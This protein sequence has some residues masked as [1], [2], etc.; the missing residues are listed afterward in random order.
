MT[1]P[2]TG[3]GSWREWAERAQR[4]GGSTFR[5]DGVYQPN[6]RWHRKHLSELDLYGATVLN[7]SPKSLASV[8]EGEANRGDII[9]EV[10]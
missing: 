4:E 9:E 3:F 10:T 8:T 7:T 6:S 2:D 1:I 5:I